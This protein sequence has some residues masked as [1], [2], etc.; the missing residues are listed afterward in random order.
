MT[1]LVPPDLEAIL[2]QRAAT[3]H[4]TLSKEMIFLIETGLAVS[5]EKV[6]EAMHLFYKMNVEVITTEPATDQRA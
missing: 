5:S 1:M 2:R 4:R 3:N 6:R